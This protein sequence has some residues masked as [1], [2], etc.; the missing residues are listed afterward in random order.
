VRALGLALTELAWPITPGPQPPDELGLPDDLSKEDVLDSLSPV[1]EV[2]NDLNH[3]GKYGEA[4][5]LHRMVLE[6]RQ[7]VL[8]RKHLDTLTSQEIMADDLYWQGKYR[9]AEPL[10]EEVLEALKEIRGDEHPET[11]AVKDKLAQARYWQGK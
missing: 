3:Q 9:D 1:D 8:G 7:A 6:V 4:E 11:L 2:A 5:H 10:Y